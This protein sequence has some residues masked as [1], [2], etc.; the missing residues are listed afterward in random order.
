MTDDRRDRRLA[1]WCAAAGLV[2]L[3]ALLAAIQ[4]FASTYVQR[5]AVDV[6]ILIILTVSL[7]LSNGYS[8][9]FSL[10]HVG[11]MAIGAYGSALLTM[12]PQAKA[13]DLP[14]LPHWLGQLQLPFPVAMLVFG[15][16]AAIVAVLVG[17]PILRLTGPYVVVATLGFLIIVHVVIINANTYTRGARTFLGL[18]PL[19]NLWWAYGIALLTVLVTWR[20]VRSPVGRAMM[21]VREDPAAARG[22]GIDV[23]RARIWA[24]AVSAFFTAV[25]GALWAH[26]I[27]AFSAS[28]FYFTMTFEVVVM[29]IVGGM[30]SIS[31]SVV[32]AAGL[33]VLSEIL[34]G[35]EGG[36]TILGVHTPAL[37]G[38]SQVV[39][40]VAF[41]AIIL[42]RP[43]GLFGDRE[44]DVVA[45][46]RRWLPAP[47]GKGVPPGRELAS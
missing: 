1:A 21:A 29:L 15:V 24:F 17:A 18:A 32:A 26:F 38:L 30:G 4:A 2:L 22:V 9:T 39:F 25:A 41:I 6:A 27:L 8:G 10:G 14:D 19:T 44:I 13:L 42:F 16:A 23:L 35:A 36:V 46:M 34:R 28:S 45:V 33:T 43:H 5:V 11:F 37:Y 40:A 3:V 20:L 47:G 31:G 7:N 12:T